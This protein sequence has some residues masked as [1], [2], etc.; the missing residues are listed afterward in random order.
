MTHEVTT[1]TECPPLSELQRLMHGRCTEARSS[2]LCDHV[3]ACPDCQ[4]RLDSLTGSG[5]D[6]AEHLR[7]ATQET[8]AQNS[9]YWRALRDAEDE[10]RRTA[11]FAT[12]GLA[13]TPAPENDLKLEFLQP[14]DKAD[15][16]GKLAQFEIVR[17]VG[18]GGMG[19]V[20]QAYDPSL[21]RNVAIKVIDPQLANNEVARQRFCREARAAAAVTHDNLVAVHQVNEDEPSGL[22]Y[23]VMQLIQGE[24]L[25][26]RIKRG[27]KLSAG[28]VARLGMQAAAGL[29]AAHAGGL[30]HRDIKPG[31]ILLEAPVDRVKL[32]DFG[33]ARAAEDVKLTRTGFVAG[34][35]LYMAPEQA[36]GEP[37]DTRA[38]L[39][40]LGTVLYEAAT[41]VA[42]FDAKTPLAVLRRVSDETQMP[43]VRINPDIP[44][45]LSDAVD[46]LLQKEPAERFQSAAEVA[47]VFA[48]GLAEMHMLSPLDVPAEVCAGSRSSTRLRRQP[49]CWKAVA[50]RSKAWAGGSALGA[51]AVG[52]LWFS[53]G[54]NGKPVNAE[55]VL[56]PDLVAPAPVAADL[57]QLVTL[58]GIDV[59]SGAARRTT[60]NPEPKIVLRGESGAVWA[61]TF[62]D[63]NQLVMGMESGTVKIWDW[64]RGTVRNELNHPDGNSGNIW[65]A[66]ACLKCKYLMVASDDSAVTFWNL[67]NVQRPEF[68]FPESTSTK[69]AAFSPNGKYLATGSRNSQVKIWDWANNIAVVKL[70][71]RGTVHSVAYNPDGTQLA[72]AGSDGKVKVWNLKNVNW[73]NGE[74][75]V[76][77][78]DLAQHK[79]GVYSVVFSPDG[80]RIA[81]AGWDGYVRIWDAVNGTQLQPIK[82][83]D[84]DAWSVSF[85]NN[86]K[87]VASAGSD[88]FVKVWDVETGAEVFSFHGPTAYHV[89]RFAR[90]GTTLAAGGRDGTVKVWE[91][92]K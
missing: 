59:A 64:Q 3:G 85:G 73:I 46:R 38:D 13:D 36:R 90:D 23:L 51:I 68:S 37:V 62:L 84:L 81:S 88:G 71:H 49:I 45:W 14:P 39:F 58:R 48:E 42:P 52:A 11:F 87:W 54:G 61:I 70:Q 32:T 72:S 21:D 65:A 12:G 79:G 20:L 86:G 6:L 30:I 92:K 15:Q 40:S 57:T 34:S 18:R 41:G 76:E 22:P 9:A 7:E 63:N 19:V 29:A 31:N 78:V 56:P 44:K 83:H 25:E 43:L 75:A 50:H 67:Q 89:V 74:G 16:L 47:E 66:D 10:L 80:S 2:A 55:P 53:L 5:T 69:T 1:T 77:S 4:K 27:G 24:S 8:P 33:L 82:A 91:I 60:T 26:Q 17:V 35:P 28:E